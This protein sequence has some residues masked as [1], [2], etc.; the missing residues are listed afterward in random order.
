MMILSSVIRVPVNR[1]TRRGCASVF[2]QLLSVPAF[3][4]FAFTIYD[5][6][7]AL[8]WPRPAHPYARS[9]SGWDTGITRPH[10]FTPITLLILRRGQRGL[11]ALLV[12]RNPSDSWASA[13]MS[14]FARCSA[15]HGWTYF[16]SLR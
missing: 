4:R 7:L 8:A 15:A 10:S 12:L 16:A 14:H 3:G 5:I 2:K 13:L 6:P 9:K 1:T 11:S